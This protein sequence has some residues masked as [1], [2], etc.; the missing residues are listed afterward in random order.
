MRTRHLR[1]L[2]PLEV[3]VAGLLAL[4]GCSSDD[5]GD[6]GLGGGRA[7]GGARDGQGGTTLIDVGAS[8]G[9]SS[10][11]GSNDAPGGGDQAG[12]G[13]AGAAAGAAAE[14]G[15]GGGTSS[16][17]MTGSG[18][19]GTQP[20]GAICSNDGNCSQSSGAVVCCVNTC[21]AADQCP[22][23]PMYLPCDS[24][25]DCSAYGG[26]KLCCET[27]SNGQTMSF[28]TKQSA[29]TGKVLR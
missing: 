10:T 18:A 15:G 14:A 2:L 28:C 20:L 1:L 17:G 25:A 19:S 26:G 3:A 22:K 21:T 16:A 27:T 11:G 6:R 8:G 7:S 9:S 13:A 4:G 5:A 29:C 23:N 24:T 12:A